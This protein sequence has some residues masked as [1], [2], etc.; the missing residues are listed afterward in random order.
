M[1]NG[2]QFHAAMLT[3]HRKR[4]ARSEIAY[5]AREQLEQ[6]RIW[7]SRYDP[8]YRDR[9]WGMRLEDGIRKALES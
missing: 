6:S 5:V 8:E 2:K 1:Y 9:D 3:L 4:V 7:L